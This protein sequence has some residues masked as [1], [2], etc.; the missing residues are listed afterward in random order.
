MAHRSN[1]VK[2]EQNQD[3]TVHLGLINKIDGY[4]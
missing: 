2:H 4:L 1:L 3:S